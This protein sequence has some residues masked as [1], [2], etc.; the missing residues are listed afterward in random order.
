MGGSKAGAAAH[1]TP[2]DLTQLADVNV[3]SVVEALKARAL[4]GDIY[5]RCGP[6]LVAV[7]PY[8]LL[9][10]YG[11][12]QLQRYLSSAESTSLPA[13]V[14]GVGAVVVQA[15]RMSHQSQAVIVSGESG[16]GKTE[17][18]KRLLEYLSAASAGGAAISRNMHARV[19]QVHAPR[20]PRR[21]VHGRDPAAGYIVIPH[22]PLKS[23]WSL[24]CASRPAR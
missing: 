8:R 23:R 11:D 16:A 13:H 20:P 7:N 19:I 1:D 10:I 15:F 3:A 9:P 24:A 5:S 6:L 18:C 2:E 14:Y 17:T 22:P 4:R 12:E 21:R